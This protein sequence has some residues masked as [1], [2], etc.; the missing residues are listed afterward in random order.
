ME[1]IAEAVDLIENEKVKLIENDA[2][3]KTYYTFPTKED[4]AIFIKK[5]KKFF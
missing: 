3:K 4:V 5:G 1:A 2:N